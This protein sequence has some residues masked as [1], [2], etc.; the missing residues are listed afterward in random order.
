MVRSSAC[1]SSSPAFVVARA[2]RSEGWV[3]VR[4]RRGAPAVAVVF[5]LAS[6]ALASPARGAARPASAGHR[7]PALSPGPRDALTRALERGSI[8]QA[9]YALRRAEALFHPTPASR[10]GASRLSSADPTM[11]LRDLAL[12]VNQL[13]PSDRREA[14]S[15]LA[16]PTSGTSDPE[17]P[18]GHGYSAPRSDYRDSCAIN[19][20]YDA[21]FCFHWVVST[22]D[23]PNLTD[24]CSV[25]LTDCVAPG[26]GIPDWV[27]VTKSVMDNVW[28]TEIGSFG[29][30]TPKDDSSSPNVRKGNPNGEVDIYLRQLR[31]LGFYGYCTSDDPNLFS[32]SYAFSDMSAYCVLDND[33]VNYGY[34][35]RTIPLKVTAAHEF[36]HAIQFSYD[37]FE[38]RW[39]MEGTAVWMEDQV[40]DNLSGNDSYDDN[41]QYLA[42]SPLTYSQIS[43]D[44]LTARS[45]FWIYGTWIFFRFLSEYS[46]PSG[47][48]LGT[49]AIK[50]IWDR[51]DGSDSA[52]GV[53]GTPGPN[54]Y[55]TQ[56]INHVIASHGTT[57]TAAFSTFDQWLALPKAQYEEGAYYPAPTVT[58][59]FVLT[60]TSP[61]IPKTTQTLSHMSQA[62][63]VVR[64]G[65]GVAPAA[66]LRIAL[67]GP[68]GTFAA[69][70]A[71]VV[72][73]GAPVQYVPF[74][75]D[76]NGDGHAVVPFGRGTVTKVMLVLTNAGHRFTNCSSPGVTLTPWSCSGVPHDDHQPYV[77]TA[78]TA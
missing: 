67:N 50:A 14:L 26:D 27:D 36:F 63:F 42:D 71:L 60:R 18:D 73:S 20:S 8:G 49:D 6:V 47:G 52:G 37:I 34:D 21:Q 77:F 55:S 75:L 5:V 38:D 54:D 57:F 35:D 74:A 41:Y 2:G 62:F 43:L 45:G 31:P 12:R 25:A 61:S 59:S 9:R 68:A 58:K 40:Y 56:A 24:D 66:K 28:A 64:P 70:S 30:K 76:A 19:A 33:Y 32:S 11:V 46:F 13:S 23:A 7:L 65:K 53:P 78:R 51:A 69:A 48:L 4:G 10:G 15:L 39:L 3:I 22:K 44:N 29:F 72:S 1:P 17:S 16:R